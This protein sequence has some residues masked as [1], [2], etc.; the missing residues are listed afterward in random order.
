VGV[1]RH[2]TAINVQRTDKAV[3][4][5]LQSWWSFREGRSLQQCE[6]FAI[7]LEGALRHSA[8]PRLKGFALPV[9]RDA[10]PPRATPQS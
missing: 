4:D 5:A 2:L 8:D 6:V 3:F 9:A 1:T 10:R 7:L